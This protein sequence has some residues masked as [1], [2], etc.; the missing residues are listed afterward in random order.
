[1]GTEEDWTG[2]Y[3]RVRPRMEAGKKWKGRKVIAVDFER[4]SGAWRIALTV[5]TNKA[6]IAKI[7]GSVKRSPSVNPYFGSSLE[8][9]LEAE[10]MST[11]RLTEPSGM[12]TAMKT[13]PFEP[14][15]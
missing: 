9:F 6:D 3:Y 8:D 10:E 4:V 1:V 13:T 2:C 11:N 5:V 15:A 12:S 14:A 7:R